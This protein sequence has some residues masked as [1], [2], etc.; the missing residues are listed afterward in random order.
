M[1][2]VGL[3]QRKC[4]RFGALH[5]P[6]LY[7]LTEAESEFKS[8]IKKA[9][10]LYPSFVCSMLNTL[11]GNDITVQGA[12]FTSLT[13]AAVVLDCADLTPSSELICSPDIVSAKKD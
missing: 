10:S 12:T 1:K 7:P 4:I 3:P 9:Y 2:Q 13:L 8:G 5:A 11:K 6:L